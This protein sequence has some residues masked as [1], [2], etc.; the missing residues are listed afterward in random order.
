MHTRVASCDARCRVGLLVQVMLAASTHTSTR[1]GL[2]GKETA[3][4]LPRKYT[5]TY[6]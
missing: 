4:A 5:R 2:H 1:T 3:V 6:L